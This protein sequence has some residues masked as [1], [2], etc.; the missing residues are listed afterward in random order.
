L[1][2]YLYLVVDTC[3]LHHTAL[4]DNRNKGVIVYLSLKSLQSI[5]CF[6]AAVVCAVA[7]ITRDVGGAT[8][9]SEI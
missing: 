1:L 4:L 5:Y 3:S 7:M 6:S 9:P 2:F 8:C